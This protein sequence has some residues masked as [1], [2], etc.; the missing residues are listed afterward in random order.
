MAFQISKLT[1]RF[2]LLKNFGLSTIAEH[3]CPRSLI[4]PS[5][6]TKHRPGRSFHAVVRSGEGSPATTTPSPRSSERVL[7]IVKRAARFSATSATSESFEWQGRRALR[8]GA[9]LRR[10]TAVFVGALGVSAA[11]SATL[12]SSALCAMASRTALNLD[13]DNTDWEEAKRLLLSM[14]LQERRGMYRTDYIPLDQIPVWNVEHL[15]LVGAASAEPI[16][17]AND[18]LNRKI[19]VFRG[20]ITKLEI[21]A[22][23]NAANKTLLGGGGVDGAIHRGAG[24]LLKRECSTL[25]GCETGEAKITGAYGLPAKYVI[26]TVGP[27]AHGSVGEGERRALRECY[28]NCLHTATKNRLRYPPEQAVEVALKTVREYL[29]EHHAQM[30]RVIFCVFLK[31]DEELYRNR[32]PAYFPQG[33]SCLAVAAVLQCFTSL[34]C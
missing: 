6:L 15:C 28:Y 10:A 24:P 20:D 5:K 2:S 25:G 30:D 12:H 29:E 21:D 3:K 16:Y 34:Q 32:L 17:K 4:H 1:A 8:K 33:L 31:A 14:N 26:H 11:V 18:E 13:S 22:I 9:S 19:S 23:A 27:I 7:N